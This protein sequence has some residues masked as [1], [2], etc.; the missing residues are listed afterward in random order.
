MYFQ[1]CHTAHFDVLLIEYSHWF[2]TNFLSIR[3]IRHA[4]SGSKV[5]LCRIV[6]AGFFSFRN[7]FLATSSIKNSSGCTQI[8]WTACFTISV[9]LHACFKTH[10]FLPMFLPISNSSSPPLGAQ[11]LIWRQP[12][13]EEKFLLVTRSAFTITNNYHSITNLAV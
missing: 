4:G 11:R 8:V 5:S 2:G 10:L 13:P 12:H 6:T 7:F 9:L 3:S 1:P